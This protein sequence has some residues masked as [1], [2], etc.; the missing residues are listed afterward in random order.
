MHPQISVVVPTRNE[1]ANVQRLHEELQ[2]AMDGLDSGE[3]VF[4]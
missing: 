4:V 2:L 3:M 1:A